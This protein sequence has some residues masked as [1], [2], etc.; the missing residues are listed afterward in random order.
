MVTNEDFEAFR[1]YCSCLD[2][3]DNCWQR[4]EPEIDKCCESTCPRINEDI[5]EMIERETGKPAVLP[6]NDKETQE[7]FIERMK[8]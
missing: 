8:E 5:I 7:R 1:I 3:E 2:E 6:E 4:D